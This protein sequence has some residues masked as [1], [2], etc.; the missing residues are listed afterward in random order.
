MLRLGL[1][2]GIGSG[3]STV[4]SI[5]QEHGAWLVDTDAIAHSLT[6]S[7]GAAMPAIAKRFGP[8]AL[9]ADG[10]LNRARMREW[11]FQDDQA[12][13]DL[14]AIVHPWV[15][16]QAALQAEAVR[17]AGAACVV[18]D[19]PL[20]VESGHWRA[21]VDRV[22][23]V[24]CTAQTQMR[25][26]QARN[27]WET[28]AVQRVIDA[29]A[30]RLQRRAAADAVIFNDGLPWSELASEVGRLAAAFGLSSTRLSAPP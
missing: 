16:Q 27:G 11:V 6:A 24:D 20:L 17:Q 5:L 18:F 8:E 28:A 30:T 12:R 9:A 15:G 13:L 23:V 4:A 29:Q 21:R 22:V 26:V 2:G 14:Q 25:R 3:K 10:S 7:G 1:T 19:V